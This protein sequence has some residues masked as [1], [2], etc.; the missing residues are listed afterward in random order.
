MLHTQPQRQTDLA[1]SDF[2]SLLKSCLGTTFHKEK[3]FF[4]FWMLI[5]CSE[6]Q[7]CPVS[8]PAYDYTQSVYTTFTNESILHLLQAILEIEGVD[9][10][11]FSPDILACLP[12]TPW[13]ITSEEI[14]K[15]K[16]LR[17]VR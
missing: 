9:T 6:A 15:R 10:S 4:H 1:A 14:S 12:A 2:D 5:W 11:E 17:N 7:S 13:C 8:N 16:D 3:H